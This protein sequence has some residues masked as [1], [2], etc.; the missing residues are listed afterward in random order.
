MP[1]GAVEHEH[2][3]GA[4]RDGARDLGEMLVHGFRVCVG[5]DQSGAGGAAGADGPEDIGPLVAR[6]ADGAGAAS[7]PRPDAGE[8]PLLAD[9]GLILESDF[10]RFFPRRVG[11]RRHYLVGNFF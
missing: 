5:H 2:G 8:S 3:M 4:G 1:S 9:A 6:V 7:A 11:D 10:Q